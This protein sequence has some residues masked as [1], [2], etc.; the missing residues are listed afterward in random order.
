MENVTEQIAMEQIARAKESATSPNRR[1]NAFGRG[2]LR[3]ITTSRAFTESR[4]AAGD[5]CYA[6][7]AGLYRRIF[8]MID[9]GTLVVDG[10]MQIH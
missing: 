5:P 3:G 8:A 2:F 7:T 10:E 4:L 6:S 1:V 9:A